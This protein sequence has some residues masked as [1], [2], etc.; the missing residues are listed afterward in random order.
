MSTSN[1]KLLLSKVVSQR[2]LTPSPWGQT[3]DATREASG[4]KAVAENHGASQ[5]DVNQALNELK[6]A[7]ANLDGNQRYEAARKELESL[8]ESIREK[9]PKSELIAQAEA[10]LVSQAPTPQA[11]ADMKEKLNKETNSCRR[12]PSCR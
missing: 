7:G 5:E 11:F 4:A 8:L 9:Y 6:Q 12:K 1:K 2:L 10:L 3:S